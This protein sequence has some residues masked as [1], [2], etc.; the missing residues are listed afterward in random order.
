MKSNARLRCPFR[1]GTCEITR[2]TRRQCQACRLRKCLESG[3]RKESEWQGE[4][5]GTGAGTGAESGRSDGPWGCVRA[6][7]QPGA[8]MSARVCT[9]ACGL[10]ATG[11]AGSPSAA[12][13]PSLLGDTTD[14]GQIYPLLWV[15][16]ESQGRHAP[17]SPHVPL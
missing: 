8:C 12:P 16:G 5:G 13:P 7:V 6:G 2:T 3:M 15:R 4:P 14:G 1:K 10:W 9:G 11:R 17:L